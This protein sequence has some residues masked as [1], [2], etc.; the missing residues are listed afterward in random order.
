[1]GAGGEKAVEL[2][3]DGWNIKLAM[4]HVASV[5]SIDKPTMEV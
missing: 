1:M 4:S 2:H 3:I 5:N